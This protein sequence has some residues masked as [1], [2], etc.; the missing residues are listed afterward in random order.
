MDRKALIR[1]YKD[2]RRPMGV[3]GVRNTVNGRMFIGTTVDLPSMLNRQRAQLRMGGH[4][5]KDLQRDWNT[6]GPDAFAFEVVD[7]L[8][9]PDDPAYDAS[10][11]LKALGGLWFDKLQ[12]YGDAGY[13]P[14]PKGR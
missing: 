12:P 10:F 11:D 13:H 6:L 5:S 1:A 7:T 8:E 3:F 2:A 9:V 14:K 4:E